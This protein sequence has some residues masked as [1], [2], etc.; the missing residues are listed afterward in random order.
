MSLELGIVYTCQ[1]PDVE[2]VSSLSVWLNYSANRMLGEFPV[3]FVSPDNVVSQRITVSVPMPRDKSGAV[4]LAADAAAHF[5]VIASVHN[6]EHVRVRVRGGY[7]RILLNDLLKVKMRKFRVEYFNDWD[8]KTGKRTVCGQLEIVSQKFNDV[9]ESQIV[10]QEPDTLSFVD[11][12]AEFLSK[13]ITCLVARKIVP[14][15]DEAAARG[16][17]LTPVRQILSRVQAPWYNTTAGVTYAPF[18]VMLVEQSS[19]NTDYFDGLLKLALARHNRSEAWFY[20]TIDDQFDNIKADPN[21][22][23][24]EFNNVV[25]VVGDVLCMPSTSLPYISDYVD[26]NKRNMLPSKSLSG[27]PSR[28]PKML[29]PSESW[30]CAI[31][32]NGGDCEDLAR[33]INLMFQGI[34]HGKFPDDSLAFAAQRVLSL[35]VG[36]F[37]LGSVLAPSLGNEAGG[38]GASKKTD[39]PKIIDSKEDREA[40]VG[41]HMW[42]E[43]HPRKKLARMIR[44]TTQDAPDTLEGRHTQPG[45]DRLI[46][47]VLEGTGRLDPFQ[48]PIAA[49]ST[50]GDARVHQR[51]VDDEFNRRVCI[52]HLVEN[53]TVTSMMQMTRAQKLMKRVPN[54]RMSEFYM[55]STTLVTTDFMDE[56]SIMEFMW[57]T[58]GERVPEPQNADDLFLDDAATLRT[59]AAVPSASSCCCDETESSS[60]TSSSKTLPS[61]FID[62][63]S[64]VSSLLGVS[65]PIE[66]PIA[67]PKRSEEHNLRAKRSIESQFIRGVPSLH[68][69]ISKE[70]A[71]GAPMPAKIGQLPI[72]YGVDVEDKFRRREAPHVALL[73]TTSI[74]GIEAAVGGATQRQLRPVSLPGNFAMVDKLYA[75]EQQSLSAIG[76]ELR[77][78]DDE[79]S[80]A[81]AELL[82]WAKQTMESEKWIDHE[83]ATSQNLSLITLFF[84]KVQLRPKPGGDPMLVANTI[85]KEYGNLKKTGVIKYGRVGMEVPM[86]RREHVVLQFLMDSSK[87]K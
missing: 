37:S 30:D 44:K 31:I 48:L 49:L 6:D 43:M 82:K 70:L 57:V 23:N 8:E 24:D 4:T 12:N 27:L 26:S 72:R 80:K 66:K 1:L 7:T 36:C 50:S 52:R 86:P 20:D 67:K 32:R 73:P 79:A 42:Y 71:L 18:Y 78:G 51:L 62:N 53:T 87:L 3:K 17:G 77:K 38:G 63:W 64:S 59:G 54:A 39:G 19:N 40:E 76:V 13:I 68:D 69:A 29:K 35:Y 83:Q 14:L 47:C 56:M 58:L 41:A 22:F 25:R 45:F 21:Y 85:M 10:F 60:A 33:L 46:S 2:Q 16:V 75:A 11:S 55:Q 84:S 15:T 81:Y 74:D 61:H 9:E 5:E 65:S 34:R 28:D